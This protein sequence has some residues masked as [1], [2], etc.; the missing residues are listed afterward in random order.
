MASVRRRGLRAVF[1]R[2]PLLQEFKR[3]PKQAIGSVL[4]LGLIAGSIWISSGQIA[5]YYHAWMAQRHGSLADGQHRL[6][7][8]EAARTHLEA[9]LRVWPT[10][11][12]TRLLAARTARR[13]KLY[14]EAAAHLAQCQKDGGVPEA[15]DLENALSRVQRGEM[16]KLEEVLVSYVNRNH[17]DTTLILE[18]LIQ[19]YMKTYELPKILKCLDLWLETQ[20]DNV[21]ALVWR[22]WAQRLLSRYQEATDDYAKAVSLEPDNIEARENLAELLI[23]SH[24]G[25]EALP[26]FQYLLA[27]DPKNAALRLGL[28]RCHAEQGDLTT[29][30]QVLDE[31]LAEEPDNAKA[32]AERGRLALDHGEPE[33][34]ERWLRRA[35]ALAPNERETL[36]SMYRCLVQL[37][38]P[39]EAQEYDRREKEIGAA[40]DRLKD[41]TRKI[42]MSP[43]DADLRCEAGRIMLANQQDA[44]GLRWLE[45]ALKEDPQ[46]APTH[47]ALA[48]Y[49]ERMH[50]PDRAERHRQLALQAKELPITRPPTAN[51]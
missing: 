40:L 29:A 19:G 26:H 33:A 35:L 28:A 47:L 18:A 2:V 23:F 44:D 42:M 49:Y 31:L 36:Y 11:A 9:C 50:Q 51:P 20:P 22:G 43:H 7:H 12:D 24:K 25:Q 38:K 37:G 14:D 27:A 8:L 30:A 3:R 16:Q 34:A 32:L 39:D 13:L 45:S 6:R 48:D 17:P 46:H 21:Q 5:A 4:L 10:S 1:R 41:L 15:I